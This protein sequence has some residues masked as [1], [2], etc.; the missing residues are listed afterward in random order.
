MEAGTP[1]Q[2]RHLGLGRAV[3]PESDLERLLVQ[4]WKR[5]LAVDEIGTRDSFSSLGGD[6]LLMIEMLSELDRA[7]ICLSYEEMRPGTTIEDLASLGGHREVQRAILPSS[8][9]LPLT[10]LQREILAELNPHRSF[11]PLGV[12]STERTVDPRRIEESIAA[13]QQSFDVL[14]TRFSLV[15]DEWSQSPSPRCSKAPVFVASTQTGFEQAIEQ[16]LGEH[17]VFGGSALCAACQSTKQRTLLFVGV[18]HLVAD[19]VSAQVLRRRLFDLL[20]AEAPDRL[21]DDKDNHFFAVLRS[22]QESLNEPLL[23]QLTSRLLGDIDRLGTNDERWRS[24]PIAVGSH[25]SFDSSL[26]KRLFTPGTEGNT[27][28]PGDLLIAAVSRALDRWMQ[29]SVAFHVLHHGRPSCSLPLHQAVGLFTRLVPVHCASRAGATLEETAF[30]V[31]QILDQDLSGAAGFDEAMT[32]SG[33][34]SRTRLEQHPA[35]GVRVN[36]LGRQNLELPDRGGWKAEIGHPALRSAS[37]IDSRNTPRPWLLITIS[38]R[39]Q[40]TNFGIY[41]RISGDAQVRL[42]E[43]ESCLS[44]EVESIR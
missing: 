27:V 34:S 13:L 15:D 23:D 9:A 28:P 31:R 42:E 40:I 43:L 18:H 39:A 26:T 19:M 11:I 7:G 4:I 41:L 22:K 36:L 12:F 35:L 33:K 17:D 32:F 37:L 30:L 5:T 2:R 1:L 14:G 38:T 8:V 6:S 25:L 24:A 29:R 3:A 20:S 21:A 10:P 16:A 44:A